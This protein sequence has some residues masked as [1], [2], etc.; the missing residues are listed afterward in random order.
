MLELRAVLTSPQDKV[1]FANI[2]PFELSLG[3]VISSLPRPS[4]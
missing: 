1:T 2:I 4:C 3:Q